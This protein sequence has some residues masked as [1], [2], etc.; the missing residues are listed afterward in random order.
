V[1]TCPHEGWLLLGLVGL[2][3]GRRDDAMDIVQA[4][5]LK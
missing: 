1:A 2:S 4:D 3:E 5:S